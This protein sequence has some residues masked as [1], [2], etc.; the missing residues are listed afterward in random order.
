MAKIFTPS[1]RI[2]LTNVAV[3][4]LKKQ[5]KRFEIACYKNKVISWRNKVDT[6]IDDVLQSQSIF[7]NV[8]KGQLAKKE[9]LVE[10]FGTDD[11]NKICLEVNFFFFFLHDDSRLFFLVFF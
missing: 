6:D 11:L 7:T 3:V 9:D 4:K 8:S 1:N 2:Q 10:V 5:G